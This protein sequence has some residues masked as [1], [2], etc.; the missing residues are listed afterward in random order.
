M[1]LPTV[2]WSTWWRAGTTRQ[3]LATGSRTPRLSWLRLAIRCRDT[4]HERHRRAT[5]PR[6]PTTPT[7]ALPEP[8]ISARAKRNRRALR[9]SLARLSLA[10]SQR[11]P[12]LRRRNRAKARALC[13]EESTRQLAPSRHRWHV[14]EHRRWL[15]AVCRQGGV[16]V[17]F[18][19]WS[20]LGLISGVRHHGLGLNCRARLCEACSMTSAL[21]VHSGR[22]SEPGLHV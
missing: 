13:P 10:F 14:D 1:W 3:V 17:S 5:R 9:I 22:G 19:L 8:S 7:A 21:N 6:R 2:N 11:S 20:P 12:L 16:R 18:D 15:V 4:H